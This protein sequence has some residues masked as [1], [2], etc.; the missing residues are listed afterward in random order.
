[1]KDFGDFAVHGL[2]CAGNSEAEEVP[3]GLV[4]EADAEDGDCFMKAS[5]GF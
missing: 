4:A 1:M 3:N 5:D 2:S